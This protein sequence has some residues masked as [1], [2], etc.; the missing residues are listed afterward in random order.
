MRHHPAVIALPRIAGI[1]ALGL[2][3]LIVLAALYVLLVEP[4]PQTDG[5][6]HPAFAPPP[7]IALSYPARC[8]AAPGTRAQA[9]GIAQGFGASL[10][11][12][13]QPQ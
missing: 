13:P 10:Q 12:L 3:M 2:A 7:V 6:M 5:L 1:C 4:S 9:R 11:G 8:F